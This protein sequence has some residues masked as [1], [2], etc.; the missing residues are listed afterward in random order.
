LGGPA[1]GYDDAWDTFVSTVPATATLS[2]TLHNNIPPTPP[3]PHAEA[4]VTD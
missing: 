4:A 1:Y 2:V 3:R